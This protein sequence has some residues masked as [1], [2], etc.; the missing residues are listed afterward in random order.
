CA[1]F[2]KKGKQREASAH[3][4]A[5]APVYL[6]IRRQQHRNDEKP[7]PMLLQLRLRL[8]LLYGLIGNTYA[9]P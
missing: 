2:L 7:M 8:R 1:Q 3:D 5:E 9:S 6:E 4:R